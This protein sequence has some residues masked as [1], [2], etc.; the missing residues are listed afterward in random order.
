MTE[1]HLN[2]SFLDVHVGNSKNGKVFWTIIFRS[3]NK[4]D[5][6]NRLDGC[7]DRNSRS[8][9]QE[10]F[11]LFFLFFSRKEITVAKNR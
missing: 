3:G 7:K 4:D 8:R 5:C 9:R 10:L 2:L 6:S 11:F 1:D